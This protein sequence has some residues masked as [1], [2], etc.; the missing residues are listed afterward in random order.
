MLIGLSNRNELCCYENDNNKQNRVY[1]I[2]DNQFEI[3]I[4]ETLESYA[5]YV[6]GKISLN[7]R[8]KILKTVIPGPGGCGGMYTASTMSIAIE[9]LGMSPLYS[10]S[11]LAESNEKVFECQNDALNIIRILIENDIKPLDII[12]KDSIKNAVTIIMAL[13]GSTNGV[14]HMLAIAKSAGIEFT[15][16]DIQQISDT[17]PFIGNLKPSGKYFIK[18]LKEIGGTP[19]IIKYLMDNGLINGNCMTITGKTMKEN[20]KN[21][22]SNMIFSNQQYN[23][24]IYPLNNPIKKNGHLTIY[25]G[26]L[27]NEGSVGKITG[28]EGLYFKGKA[29]VYNSQDE[30]MDAFR[31]GDIKKPL[32]GEKY[33]IIIRYEGPKG[34]PGMPEMLSPTATLVGA[35]LLNDYAL[36]TDGRFSGASHGFIIGHVSPEAFDGGNLALINNNDIIEIDTDKREINILIDDNELNKRRIQW[37]KNKPKPRFNSGV[38]S[39]YIQTVKSASVGCVTD[40]F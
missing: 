1:Y 4:K 37:N 7:D 27:C 38:L 18:Y 24:I 11:N 8:M 13:G 34:G 29:K 20:L 12:T 35:G 25:Y 31:N 33:I 36:I 14:L 23:D 32:N 3:D 28:K 10:S 22:D 39:K 19:A 9:A 5:D 16:D 2:D 6:S 17:T 26:N 30:Y 21:I 15:L 40:S